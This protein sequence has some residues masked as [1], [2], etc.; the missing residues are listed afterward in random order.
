ALA[1]AEKLDTADR[2]ARRHR[3]LDGARH[4]LRDTPRPTIAY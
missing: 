2:A 3:Y 1:E 4:A